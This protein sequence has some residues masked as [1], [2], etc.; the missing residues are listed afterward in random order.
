[1]REEA[2]RRRLHADTS[3][4]ES[5]GEGGAWNGGD[6]SAASLAENVYAVPA[7]GARV[8]VY[9]SKALLFH[10]CTKLPSDK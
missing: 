1:M 2:L 8:T 3:D 10:Y 5:D 9:N 6:G 7:T 4:S